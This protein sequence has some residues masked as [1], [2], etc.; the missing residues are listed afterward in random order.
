MEWEKESFIFLLG[1]NPYSLFRSCSST[2]RIPTIFERRQLRPLPRDV[3][4]DLHASKL[5]A[6]THHNFVGPFKNF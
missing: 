2:G 3:R 4:P 6:K 5:F 1:S